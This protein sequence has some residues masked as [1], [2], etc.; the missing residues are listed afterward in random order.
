M[1]VTARFSRNFPIV[2]PIILM[3]GLLCTATSVSPQ[4]S[5][6]DSAK[7]SAA[8]RLDQASNADR[9]DAAALRA[10]ADQWKEMQQKAEDRSAKATDP[11]TKSVWKETAL[12]H[13]EEAAHLEQQAAELEHRAADESAQAAQERVKAAPAPNPRPSLRHRARQ[14]RPLLIPRLTPPRIPH[15]HRHPPLFLR[16]TSAVAHALNSQR[17]I[18]ASLRFRATFTTS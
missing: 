15:P 14:T 18:L 7:A 12:R 3:I 5:S 11:V 4:S 6:G 2:V 1:K 16:P 10:R 13:A 8:E 9:Q 17:W